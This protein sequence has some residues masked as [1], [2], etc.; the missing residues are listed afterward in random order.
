MRA[1]MA[2]GGANLIQNW[3]SQTNP[4]RGGEVIIDIT[5]VD[6]R[7]VVELEAIKIQLTVHFLQHQHSAAHRTTSSRSLL[8]ILC[9][10]DIIPYPPSHPPSILARIAPQT[11]LFPDR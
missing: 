1:E 8:L 4:Y 2:P 9:M 7:F 11:E 5:Q 3:C 6:K 10:R